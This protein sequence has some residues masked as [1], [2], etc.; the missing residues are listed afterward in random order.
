MDIQ[1]ENLLGRLRHFYENIVMNIIHVY[2][3]REVLNNNTS[4]HFLLHQNKHTLFHEYI[5]T[6]LCCQCQP[7]PHNRLT[8][9]TGCLREYQFFVLYKC[10]TE[11]RPNHEKKD[12]TKM[13]QYC[14]CKFDPTDVKV[15]QLDII[16]LSA[17]VNTCMKQKLPA[18][19]D[20]K[21]LRKIKDV[22]NFIYH[23]GDDSCLSKG[24]F[25]E[26]WQILEECSLSMAKITGESYALGIQNR[27]LSLVK[28]SDV[29]FSLKEV[30]T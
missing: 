14:L 27:I 20:P 13:K 23:H 15:F 18:N 2:F 8:P 19:Y 22:R 26:K 5:P 29:S 1:T 24:S 4:F 11:A 17:I 7:L 16:L 10:S 12:D 3:E 28:E 25:N 30:C 9:R 6:V 21:W